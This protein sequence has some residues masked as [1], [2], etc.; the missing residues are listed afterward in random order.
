MPKRYDKADDDT[1]TLVREV[2]EQ[3]HQELVRAG[4]RVQCLMV[5][6]AD[7]TGLALD[8]QAL[9]RQGH[10]VAGQIRRCHARDRR[11]H[12]ADAILELDDYA[13]H[14]LSTEQARALIDHE[15]THLEVVV[16]QDGVT[17]KHPD[18]RPKLSL[19]HDDFMLTG[20]YDVVER[21]G[22]A[23]LEYQSVERVYKQL[24]FAD[25]AEPTESVVRST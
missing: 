23:A 11:I 18:G 3:H 16:D 8:V 1:L 12:E 24:T 17:A 19:R 10:P 14:P 13:W 22:T 2:M 5:S 7:K 20:F 15:L 21:H 4:V 6:E 25:A 9:T